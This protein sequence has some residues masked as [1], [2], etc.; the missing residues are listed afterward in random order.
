[1][2]QLGRSN[3][4]GERTAGR[5]AVARRAPS[6]HPLMRLQR[7][8]GNQAVAAMLAQRQ[9]EEDELA[10]SRDPAMQRQEGGELEEEE[11]ALSRDPAVQ[12]QGEEDELQMAR[13]DQ[14]EV[15]LDGGP[16]SDATADRIQA[17]RGSGAEL[18]AEDRVAMESSF[19]TSFADV[20]LHTGG[21]ATA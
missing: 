21:E 15:G 8:V 5:S 17:A 3:Q 9:G 16:V 12:R 13:D 1:M 6:T 19:D 4:G 7:Q 11:V 20:R 14:P 2:S 10:L 18:E